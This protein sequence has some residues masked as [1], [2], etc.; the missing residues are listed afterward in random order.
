MVNTGPGINT[1]WVMLYVCLTH[2]EHIANTNCQTQFS[3]VASCGQQSKHGLTHPKQMS[4]KSTIVGAEN[5][6]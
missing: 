2:K 4:W 1:K 6:C 5:N 3:I